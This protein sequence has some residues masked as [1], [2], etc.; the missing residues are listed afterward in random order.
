MLVVLVIG[1]YIGVVWFIA[2]VVSLKGSVAA[3]SGRL[4]TL[5]IKYSSTLKICTYRFFCF[6]FSKKCITTFR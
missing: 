6:D 1:M 4:N 5:T 3:S 2:C